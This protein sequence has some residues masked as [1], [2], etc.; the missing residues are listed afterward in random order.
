MR[1]AHPSSWRAEALETLRLSVPLAAANMLQMAVYAIDV[2]FVARLGQ[3][4]LAASAVG[5]PVRPDGVERLFAGG[6]WPR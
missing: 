1:G 6:R 2:I 3:T 4:A 5:Q